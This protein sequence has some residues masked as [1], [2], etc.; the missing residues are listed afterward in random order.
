[1]LA[2]HGTV[3]KSVVSK[4]KPK[5]GIPCVIRQTLASD[6]RV[7]DLFACPLLPVA[8]H[9]YHANGGW[10]DS[11]ESPTV[12]YGLLFAKASAAADRSLATLSSGDPL[13]M[14]RMT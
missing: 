12:F 9:C 4:K 3:P 11:E 6:I 14:R 8:T 7:V 13:T 5:R 1:M 2:F 10:I